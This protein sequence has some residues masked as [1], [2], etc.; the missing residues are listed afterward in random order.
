MSVPE[1]KLGYTLFYFIKLQTFF[2][3]CE[4]LHLI[5]YLCSQTMTILSKKCLF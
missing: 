3:L 1:P 2:Y 5:I 4:S